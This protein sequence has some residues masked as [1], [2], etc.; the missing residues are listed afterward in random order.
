MR[1]VG[2]PPSGG[3]KPGTP[4]IGTATAGDASATVAYTAPTYTGKGGAVTYTA[5]STPGSFTGTGASPITVSG[6]TNGTAYTFTVRAGTSYGVNSD[7]SVASNSVTPAAAGSF[8][9]IASATGTGSSN[10]ITFSSIPSTYKHLQLRVAYF[11]ATAGDSA[12]L[13][14]NGSG[15]GY[16]RHGIYGNQAS[17]T[18]IGYTSQGDMQVDAALTGTFTNIAN[19]AIIDIHNYA[20]TTQNKTVR[21][22]Y[23]VDANGSGSIG[24]NSGLWINTSAVNSISFYTSAYN[25]TTNTVASLYG[26][27]G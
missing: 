22:F 9:S 21:F 15:T 14:L 8:E 20:S 26:I 13:R 12:F 24:M 23:G 6:L 19:V 10:I 27:K 25:F 7:E 4:T 18:A 17:V 11:T 1:I 2:N 16:T 5:T 3:K